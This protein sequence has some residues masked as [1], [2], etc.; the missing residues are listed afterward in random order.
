VL[1]QLRQRVRVPQQRVDQASDLVFGHRPDVRQARA[2]AP[3]GVEL[4]LIVRAAAS[5][6]PRVDERV[7]R[8]DV[9]QLLVPATPG[10]DQR[11]GRVE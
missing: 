4:G 8:C 6:A 2:Q 1:D 7:E 5:P 9:G 10:V 3:H 11:R